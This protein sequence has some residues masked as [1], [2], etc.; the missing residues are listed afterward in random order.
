LNRPAAAAGDKLIRTQLS[1]LIN[2]AKRS[3]R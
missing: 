1:L 3:K 2:D